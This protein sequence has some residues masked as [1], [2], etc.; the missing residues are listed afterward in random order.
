MD[1]PRIAGRR[2]KLQKDGEGEG[3]SRQTSKPQELKPRFVY[4]IGGTLK[5]VAE[6]LLISGEIGE[7]GPSGAEARGDP[8]GFMRGLKPPPPSEWSF[9]ATC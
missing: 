2:R 8:V 4:G 6:K 7:I 9:F 5:E 3:E 1:L